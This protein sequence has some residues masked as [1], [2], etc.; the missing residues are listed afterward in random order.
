MSSY[1]KI[2]LHK[3]ILI[4]VSEMTEIVNKAI[5]IH[6]LK[7]ISSLI[8]A[9]FINVFGP[10]PTLIKDK[11]TGFSVKINSETVESLVLET[12]KNGQ[13][14]A[15]FSA[16]S[17]EISAN[18]FKNYNTNQLVSSYIGTSGFLKI[19]Q[20]TKKTNYSGQVKLQRGD[21]ITDLAFYFHQS[22]QINSVV[23]NLI[24]L[25]ENSKIAKSQSLIIQLLPNHSEGELQE[26][27]SWLE[28]EKMADFMSFFSS[29]NQV[30]F[31]KWDYICNCKKAN[32]EANLK[33][34][35]QED[36][37]FLIEKYK[38]IEFKCNFC[39]NSKKFNKKD[40]LMA[41]KP[42]SIATVESLTGGALAAEIVKKPGASK[43]FAGGLV[44]Y[45]NEI[46]EKIG[47]DT[48]NGV[49]N[50]KTALK[51]AK[52]GLD[53]FQTKYAI[54]LTGNA[55]P[56]VQDGKLGQVFIAIN[57]EVWEL[58]FTGSRSEIIQASLDFAVKK[59]KEISKN[60]IKIF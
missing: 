45:Q 47:I 4:V 7:N 49:T 8:L 27:E 26:I 2:Y 13:I 16:N 5:N 53:F 6:K 42:F 1:S 10:L 37:D 19:N 18:V 43:F 24:E 17:F 25:D 12:N 3:N 15:S 23:K 60:S 28:N 44:C 9:S 33:L 55:G 41:N 31:Q 46:K 20:F 35:S 36:V 39:S 50:A 14:R 32:F 54:A 29:F 48:K 22:Q 57:D 11:T 21:F 30:D 56:T 58:N 51:M 38:K 52:Y 59:I 34:L 40:W